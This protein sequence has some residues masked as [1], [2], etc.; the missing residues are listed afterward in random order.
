RAFFALRRMANTQHGLTVSS[1]RQ[2]YTSAIL[3][4]LDY[5]AEIW[6]KGQKTMIS[7]LQNLHNTALR[8]IPGAY[9]TTPTAALEVEAAL[10]PTNLRLTYLQRKYAIRILSFPQQHI[11][12]IRCPDDLPDN[13]GGEE[14]D[15][16]WR[17]WHNRNP[18]SIPYLSQLDHI[19][20]QINRWVQPAS[21]LEQ[22]HGTRRPPWY[23]PP[24]LDIAK[25]TLSKEDTATAHRRM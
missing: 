5:G 18:S 1:M 10:P 22:T 20:A 21:Q 11:L 12:K 17:Q 3:P 19:L 24:Q 4:V 13:D 2:L 25:P 7:K 23:E 6:W 8:S 15:N 9:R 14:R 16:R